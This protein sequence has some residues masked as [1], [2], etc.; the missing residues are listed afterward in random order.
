[1]HFFS[2]STSHR[3]YKTWTPFLVVHLLPNW[4]R[5][6]PYKFR[7]FFPNCRR[8]FERPIF[9]GSSPNFLLLLCNVIV[10][11]KRHYG[12]KKDMTSKVFG[13]SGGI[14]EHVPTF[15]W[16]R[17]M[18]LFHFFVM[19]KRYFVICFSCYVFLQEFGDLLISWIMVASSLLCQ[20]VII[21]SLVSN[22]KRKSRQ[23]QEDK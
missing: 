9:L 3:C 22:H 8:K 17:S 7:I 19:S 5:D 12:D 1:M 11:S 2:I 4:K 16:L 13:C 18:I 20:K 14:P 21:F 15:G 23:E 6:F 10:V